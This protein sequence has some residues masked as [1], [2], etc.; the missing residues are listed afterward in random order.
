MPFDRLLDDGAFDAA[1][2]E[3]LTSAFDEGLKEL[4]IERTDPLADSVARKIIEVA[5]S[6]ERDPGRLRK[7]A[8]AG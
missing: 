2:V 3:A 7:L 8:T 5:R 6:G 4:G 1:A